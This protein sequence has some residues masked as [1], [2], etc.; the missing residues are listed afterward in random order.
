MGRKITALLGTLTLLAV[1][2]TASA[3]S[4]TPTTAPE[5]RQVL[6]VLVKV[7]AEGRITGVSPSTR[8]PPK[9][10][11]LLRD[12]LEELIAGPANNAAGEG[13]SSQ[14]IANMALD[15]IPLEDGNRSVQFTFVSSQ[16]VP[17][18][19]WF[20]S[21]VDNR[22]LALVRREAGPDRSPLREKPERS[23]YAPPSGAPG[24]TGGTPPPSGGKGA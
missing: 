5:G 22:R 2:G 19:S 3:E 10:S 16:P 8:L 9:L 1:A 18:G 20:W 11:R 21:H 17:P 15:A 24:N 14:F 13:I 23:G 12:N 6:P 7:N 4:L